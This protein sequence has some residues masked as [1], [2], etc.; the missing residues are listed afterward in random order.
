MHDKPWHH[1][2]RNFADEAHFGE[3]TAVKLGIFGN[4][5][6][7]ESAGKD[8]MEIILIVQGAIS[9]AVILTRLSLIT[10]LHLN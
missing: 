1:K 9:Q 7:P 8:E 3:L 6:H 10:K 4:F 5:H 2:Y